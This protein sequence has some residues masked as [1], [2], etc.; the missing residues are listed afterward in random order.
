MALLS[1]YGRPLRA[2]S[3]TPV[4]HSSPHARAKANANPPSRLVRVI[5]SS[6][7]AGS[8]IGEGDENVGRLPWRCIEW[9]FIL[10]TR[11]ELQKVPL[12]TFSSYLELDYKSEGAVGTQ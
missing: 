8:V 7:E 6:A 4:R 10:H 9:V 1:Q 11:R 5:I 2:R 3:A 12:L